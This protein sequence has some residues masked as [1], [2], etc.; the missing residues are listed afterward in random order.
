VTLAEESVLGALSL[1][2][3]STE[4]WTM[5]GGAPAKLIKQRR[6]DVIGKGEEVP[7]SSRFMQKSTRQPSCAHAPEGTCAYR[8]SLESNNRESI[9]RGNVAATLVAV[10]A[11]Y[12]SRFASCRVR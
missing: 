5:Y 3:R 11:H 7:K 4:P 2:G 10:F 8:N 1:I 12:P 6:R 9:E